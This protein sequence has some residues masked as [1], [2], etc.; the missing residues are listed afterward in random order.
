V[1]ASTNRGLPD[2]AELLAGVPR[3]ISTPEQALA[4]AHLIDE[5]VPLTLRE[6]PYRNLNLSL[7]L[8]RVKDARFRSDR[9]ELK[10]FEG[11]VLHMY[12]YALDAWQRFLVVGA[13]DGV[14]AAPGVTPTVP[15][16]T[17][18][19]TRM[20]GPGLVSSPRTAAACD[21]SPGLSRMTGVW[22]RRL[23]LPWLR[24]GEH[25]LPYVQSMLAKKNIVPLTVTDGISAI[26]LAA[27]IRCEFPFGPRPHRLLV[28]STKFLQLL[29]LE[30]AHRA[31]HGDPAVYA[32]IEQEVMTAYPSVLAETRTELESSDSQWAKTTRRQW[33]RYRAQAE[34]LRAAG[35]QVEVVDG[36]MPVPDELAL[37]S[38]TAVRVPIEAITVP[39]GRQVGD[40]TWLVESMRELGQLQPIVVAP[41]GELVAGMHRLRAAQVLGWTEIHVIVLDLEATKKK[42]AV[43]D[44]NLVRRQLPA[45]EYAEAL[46][47][48][49]ELYEVLHPETQQHRR[50]GVA[51]A[52]KS[53]TAL[54]AVA[55]SFA[56]D[57]AARV[58]VSPR[59]VREYTQVSSMTPEVRD[60]L[61]SSD[62]K[63]SVKE[64]VAV[65]RLPAS[66]Q[67]SVAAVL[68]QGGA[69]NV[70]EAVGLVR[71]PATSA[72]AVPYAVTQG[73][74][75][76]KQV[77]DIR[78]LSADVEAALKE[79]QATDPA[80]MAPFITRWTNIAASM[81][82]ASAVA[83][84]VETPATACPCGGSRACSECRGRGW[85]AK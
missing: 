41:D 50:G 1:N 34:K 67:Q 12:P 53:A 27:V 59:T 37:E 61:R 30:S 60:L 8:G 25:V 24:R 5:H 23:R 40:V 46:A 4:L 38:G 36:A 33:E 28:F 13:D 85:R 81:S 47:E 82:G 7:W 6:D 84:Q 14:A 32:S 22:T 78:R 42:L 57:T 19:F 56:A 70:R 69:K 80:G 31:G 16:S 43:L 65:A 2:F 44:E 21:P 62:I 75:I 17:A 39:A 66:E 20:T 54:S 18:T 63:N 35:P 58:G 64:L 29:E 73:P 55:Q 76:R 79:W 72:T 3:T 68:T 83:N 26:A 51:K 74:R 10:I 77:A 52:A 48:R 49:K 45:L 11:Q 9:E 71:T 15:A